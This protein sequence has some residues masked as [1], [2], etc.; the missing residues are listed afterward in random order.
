MLLDL[1]GDKDY[2][3]MNLKTVCYMISKK[4]KYELRMVLEE[5]RAEGKITIDNAGRRYIKDNIK[6]GV[7]SGTQRGY[8]FVIIEGED[9]DIFISEDY[10]GGALHGDRVL[11]SISDISSGK[12]KE[13]EI[14]RILERAN[15]V[16]VGTYQKS[17]NF[18][19]VV[20][21]NKKFN[22]DI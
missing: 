17:N 8:G 14:I 1:M 18:G 3:P 13:G 15:K 12:R 21:D 4:D 16:V 9:D 5:L 19:F 22:K 6:E 2:V 11:V 7:F 20:T 10:L